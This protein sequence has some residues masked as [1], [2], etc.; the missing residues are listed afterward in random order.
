MVQR[1]GDI[2]V[3]HIL[4]L[5]GIVFALVVMLL[6]IQHICIE[7]KM[8]EFR[9]EAVEVRV[10]KNVRIG[11]YLI[12]Y[13]MPNSKWKE[14]RKVKPSEFD[15]IN[16]KGLGYGEPEIIDLDERRWLRVRKYKADNKPAPHRDNS[17]GRAVLCSAASVKEG[18]ML[19]KKSVWARI[20]GSKNK[21][22]CKIEV[23]SKEG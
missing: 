14:I 16:M 23:I 5:V 17:I 12:K 1:K 10:K 22:E 9:E 21:R 7:G 8:K 6:A 19:R 3:I 13:R 18:G 20:N 4:C 2:S 15:S 11:F